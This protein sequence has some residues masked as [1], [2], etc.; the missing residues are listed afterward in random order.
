M[1]EATMVDNCY[2]YFSNNCIYNRIEKEV[3]FLSRCID[4]VL[5]VRECETITIEFKINNWRQAIRQAKNHMLG[6]DRAYICLPKREPSIE[7][8]N[9]LHEAGIGL[10]L[11]CIDDDQTIFECLPAPVN[12][13]KVKVFNTQ[14]LNTLDRISSN[15]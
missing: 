3:P 8:V 11:Y 14:L 9:A 12:K 4:M 10:F 13:K 5:I 7:L 2:E 1:L 6:A 15:A